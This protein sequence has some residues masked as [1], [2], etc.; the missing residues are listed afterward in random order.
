MRSHLSAELHRVPMPAVPFAAGGAARHGGAG[1]RGAAAWMKLFEDRYKSNE[2]PYGSGVWGK[3]EWILPEISDDEH[4]LALRR[5][6]EPV[7]GRALR[8]GHRGGRPV[9]QAVR[10]HPQRLLQG[11]GHDGAGLAGEADDLRGR[12]DQGGGLRFDGRH[13]GGAGD[14]LRR[15]GHPVHRAA[16]A[17]Q[18]FHRAVDPAG[19][20]RRAGALPGHGLRRLHEAGAGDHQGPDALPGQ[21]DELA[22]RR[23]P[24]DGGHRDRAAV[25]LGSAGRDHHPR[26][27]PGQR[28]GA[29]QRAADD[30]RPG[31]DREA[32]AHRGGPGGARQPALSAPTCATSRASSRSRRRRRWRARSRSATR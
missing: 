1:P 3:K 29:G 25:R 21:L 24:E 16:A 2:W 19:L 17:R 10:Q 8:E 28:L 20:Q 5:R 26:R 12:A 15:G 7:L 31:A 32:A 9:D 23:G 11:P 4:R 14:L 13:L 22:A 6:H 30:E 18:D 27:Q